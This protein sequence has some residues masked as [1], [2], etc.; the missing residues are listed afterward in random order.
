MK[1]VLFVEVLFKKQIELENPI[2]ID[3]FVRRRRKYSFFK[4][5]LNDVMILTRMFAFF[6]TSSFLKIYKNGIDFR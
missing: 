3:L 2:W 1:N 6:S 4:Y 5:I